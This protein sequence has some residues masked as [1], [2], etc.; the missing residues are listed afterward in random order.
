MSYKSDSRIWPE[1]VIGIALSALI[2]LMGFVVSKERFATPVC[3]L[4]ETELRLFGKEGFE[5]AF[6]KALRQPTIQIN[7]NQ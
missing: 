7:S 6:E 5:G 3:P 4:E 1:V 2:L